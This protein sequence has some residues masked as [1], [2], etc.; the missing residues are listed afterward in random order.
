MNTKPK[1]NLSKKDVLPKYVLKQISEGRLI[2]C[3]YL[4]AGDFLGYTFRFSQRWKTTEDRKFRKDLQRFLA[5]AIKK[6]LMQK[7]LNTRE[8]YEMDLLYGVL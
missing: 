2:P 5:F 4:L 1:D 3:K 8:M 7:S 6:M